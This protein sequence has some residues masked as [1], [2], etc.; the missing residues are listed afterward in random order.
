MRCR[1]SGA[2]FVFFFLSTVFLG[3]VE[4]ESLSGR[5]FRRALFPVLLI[6]FFWGCSLAPRDDAPTEGPE[7]ISIEDEKKLGYYM[8]AVISRHFLPLE[9]KRV[10]E[11]INEIGKGIVAQMPNPG[12]EFTFKVLNEPAKNAF[13][14][15]GGFVYITSGMLEELKTKD[16]VAAVL[17]HELAHVVARH[18]ARALYNA[19]VEAG[20][21]A[22]LSVGAA[23]GMAAAGQPAAAAD[24]VRLA[25]A[26]LIVVA[27]QGYSRSYEMQAD[28]LGLTYMTKAGYDAK[29][30]V[31]LF[32]IFMEVD[33]KEAS[34]GEK[35][36][37]PAIFSS[38]PDNEERLKT[39]QELIAKRGSP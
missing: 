22:T 2:A 27:H 36:D 6:L 18:P 23:L 21:Y 35:R 11:A 20:I 9:E 16:Q 30:M 14:G 4:S 38:H 31:Q 10:V 19:Q 33:R 1:F 5:R 3:G 7:L 13:A 37:R 8:D 26:L 28:R 12:L 39:I 15:P 29:G 24:L 17:A 32:Q 25:S 34:E